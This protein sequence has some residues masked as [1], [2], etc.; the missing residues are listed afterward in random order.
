MDDHKCRNCGFVLKESVKFCPECG[1]P[2][3]QLK[4]SE[5]PVLGDF[6]Q[7]FI[8]WDPKIWRTLKVLLT[9]P[10]KLVGEFM[11]DHKSVTSPA[12]LFV[13]ISALSFFFG[14]ITVT[15]ALENSELKIDFDQLTEKPDIELTFES[16]TGIRMEN[17]AY[18][19]PEIDSLGAEEFLTQRDNPPNGILFWIAKQTIKKYQN[20]DYR[21]ISINHQRNASFL[22]YL[23]IPF[24]ALTLKI[25]GR[26]IS[27]TEHFTFTLYTFSAFFVFQ[28]LF[29]GLGVLVYNI[30]SIPYLELGFVPVSII[31]LAAAIHFH[32]RK[33]WL[34]SIFGGISMTLVLLLS[35]LF[36]LL[37]SSLLII[38]I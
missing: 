5:K 28:M 6:F 31:Y 14:V 37:F 21:E 30:F 8:N 34:I 26:Q 4:P 2:T 15:R 11:R 7:E 19:Q 33:N 38:V 13:L 22:L 35:T 32:Y 23:L 10:G 36:L 20:N 16:S 17:I 12:K 1:T 25:F 3:T 27:M 9:K 18:Y 24:F 29:R